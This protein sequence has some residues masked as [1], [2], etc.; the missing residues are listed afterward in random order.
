MIGHKIKKL[1]MAKSLSQAELG[2]LAGLSQA[3]ISLIEAEVKSPTIR[4]LEKLAAALGVS[5]A[6][7]LDEAPS[8]PDPALDLPNQP[9]YGDGVKPYL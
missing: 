6:E 9:G 2:D 3:A 1:R 4:T 5:V 8:N 7:L